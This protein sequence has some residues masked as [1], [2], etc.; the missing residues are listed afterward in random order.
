MKEI[1]DKITLSVE[2][3][4]VNIKDLRTKRKALKASH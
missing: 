4:K 1:K 2:N 3:G